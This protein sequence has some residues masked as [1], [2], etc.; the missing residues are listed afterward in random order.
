ML[1]QRDRVFQEIDDKVGTAERAVI[2]GKNAEYRKYLSEA[3]KIDNTLTEGTLEYEQAMN[4]AY[5]DYQTKI[6]ALDDT[7]SQIQYAAEAQKMQYGQQNLSSQ[8]SKQFMST[9]VP[10]T[11]ADY[12]YIQKDPK[13][14]E[15]IKNTAGGGASQAK[16][17]LLGVIGKLR[18]GNIGAITGFTRTGWVP[19]SEGAL[20]KNYYDQLKSML[21]LENRE[22]L[23]GSGAIS[24]FEAKILANAASALGQN[25]SEDQFRLVLSDLETKLGGGQA[26]TNVNDPLGLGL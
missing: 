15:Y 16:D 22:K 6:F 5:G 10:Q 20:T 21:S 11:M 25:L 3:R 14:A 12:M 23:K 26:Q 8:L 18:N 17:E 19:G 1:A 2:Q 24:D 9:G 13:A 4:K 7:F